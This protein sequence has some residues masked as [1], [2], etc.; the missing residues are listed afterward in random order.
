MIK[1]KHRK[2]VA[3]KATG[4]ARQPQR[5]RATATPGRRYIGA[6]LRQHPEE[7]LDRRLHL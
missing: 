5:R 4:R 6:N 1:K 2:V 7:H 3:S